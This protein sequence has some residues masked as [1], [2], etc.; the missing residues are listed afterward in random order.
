MLRKHF[1]WDGFL[2]ARNL[3]LINLFF[4]FFSMA[5]EILMWVWNNYSENEHPKVHI[6]HSSN[7]MFVVVDFTKGVR[8]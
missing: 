3:V 2:T 6:S 8:S 1:I 4:F 5:T 7:W